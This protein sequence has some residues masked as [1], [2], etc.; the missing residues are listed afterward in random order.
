MGHFHRPKFKIR[1]GRMSHF[2][3]ESVS[4]IGKNSSGSVQSEL[5]TGND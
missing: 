2:L 4:E 5:K 1:E 3:S